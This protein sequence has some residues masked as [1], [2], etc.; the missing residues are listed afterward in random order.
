[1]GENIKIVSRGMGCQD[2]CRPGK[3]PLAG[4]CVH[5][6]EFRVPEKL[7][8]FDQ[9]SNYPLLKTLFYVASIFCRCFK[10]R[11]SGLYTA[12]QSRRPRIEHHRFESLKTR[13]GRRYL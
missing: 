1:V 3:G 6:N 5:G 12:S 4:R 7:G 9:L 8:F 2:S 10:S 13:I 11:S